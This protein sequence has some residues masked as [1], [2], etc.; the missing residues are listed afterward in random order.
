MMITPPSKAP[1]H[2]KYLLAGPLRGRKPSEV[3]FCIN[4]P[5]DKGDE[6]SDSSESS[7]P[8][9]F[10]SGSDEEEEDEIQQD[11]PV[12]GEEESDG[13]GNGDEEEDGNGSEE[14]AEEDEGNNGGNE[15]D[16]EDEGNDDGD[17]DDE[18]KGV[19]D[20]DDEEDEG[21][22]AGNKEGEEIEQPKPTK[23]VKKDGT[24]ISP[25]ARHVSATHLLLS[26]VRSGKP[27]GEPRDGCEVLFGYPGSHH[28]L[29]HVNEGHGATTDYTAW[30]EGFSHGR[31]IQ[32]DQ[33][34]GRRTNRASSSS[35][36]DDTRDDTTIL[37][38][39]REHM[40]LFVKALCCSAD[41]REVFD[42]EKQRWYADYCTHIEN[43]NAKK[44]FAELAKEDKL[45]LPLLLPGPPPTKPI[46]QDQCQPNPTTASPFTPLLQEI[47]L[48]NP[49]STKTPKLKNPYSDNLSSPPS[50]Y[51]LRKRTR[52][53]K[54]GD[55]NRGKPWTS[56][57]LS[58]QGQKILETLITTENN[59]VNEI[60][61]TCHHE[62][63][64]KF[65]LE[66]LSFDLLSII[67]ALGFHKKC[68][69]ALGV[70]EW[71]RNHKDS[72]FLL[73]GSVVAVIIRILG[74]EGMVTKAASLLL[75]LSKEG[76]TIDVY[77]YTSMITS[78]S[79]N[80]RYREAVSVF[81]KMEEEG[82][83]PTLITYNVI[84]NV[85]GKMGVPWSKIMD[86]V[87]GMKKQGV[88]P[89]SYTYNT[90]ISC[91]RRGSL[92]EEA[93]AVFEEMKSAGFTPDKVTYN[94]L[95]DVFGKSRRPTE[96]MGVLREM[97][98]NGFSPSTVTYN[99]LISAYAKD[100]LLDE[101]LEL[102]SLMVE[103]GIQPD[104]FTY[105]TLLSGFERA[106]K[107]EYAV[108][109]F[110]EMKRDGCKPNI[111]T[112]N[113]LIKMHGKRGKF[114][115]MMKVFEEIWACDCT[116]DIVTWNTLL[117]V[118]GQNGMDTEVS[119]VFKEMK[120]AGFVPERDTFNTLISAYSRCSSFD[121]AMSVYKMM[122]SAGVT[123]DLTTYNTVLSALARGGLWEQSEKIL[124]EM[125]DGDHCKPNELTYCSLL[126]AYANGKEIERMRALAEEIY[127]GVI[128]SNA[129]LLKTLILVSSKSNLLSEMERAFTEL[130]RKGFSLDISTLN[131]MFSIYGRRHMVAKANEVL[132]H[133]MESGFTP[134]ITTYNSLMDIYCRSGNPERA[135]DVLK[136]IKAKEL[137]PDLVSYNILI[138]GYARKG[139]MQD[140]SRILSEL[141]NSGLSPDLITYNS[142]VSCYAAH[143]M[144]AEAIDVIQYMIKHG[145]R[146]NQTTY[147]S[148]IDWY[149]KLG[150][151][152][153]ATTFVTN[154]RKLDPHVASSEESRLSARIKAKQLQKTGA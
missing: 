63:D 123:P 6:S 45:A 81:K 49:N 13:N 115:E 8:F 103:K 135:E 65:H 110:D 11:P 4:E 73:K 47:L 75:S 150:R 69:L 125:K 137:V 101:A 62:K 1:R 92:Y 130:R 30:Y 83:Q 140:A 14:E 29:A 20:K 40:K 18:G 24:D 79:N 22:D 96:A 52:I 111:C 71:M 44:M 89:D 2:D 98:V 100:A 43:P 15:K 46:F 76:V 58:V 154:L 146:P 70:F 94:T 118:F 19:G 54:S 129:V 102:K 126:H 132:N 74:R 61:D 90:L 32:I 128:E 113:A 3:A 104:V 25:S 127:S 56:E 78:C 105:T 17:K 80:G 95:L 91:C 34:S 143:S 141:T 99:A 84:L 119:G 144:F 37:A 31:V 149:C 114:T 85:Y 122:L 139:R 106:G 60:L 12:Q 97:E 5:R 28:R 82:C 41:K 26:P 42:P 23:R 64:E 68:E 142:F 50:P 145:R 39:V 51:L 136:E 35:S 117:A 48:Q 21:D 148:I 9:I 57:Q 109:V 59:D 153:E 116:P 7:S 147:N 121:Q 86:V 38:L 36:Q 108:R 66:S 134:S 152:D 16:D 120:R 151:K 112:F 72:E 27:R 53:G 87:D 138:F 77:A 88:F 131:A 33:T 67:K 107:D 10:A 93:V 55:R 124:A 133:M